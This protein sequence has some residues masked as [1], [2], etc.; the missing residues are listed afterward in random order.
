MERGVLKKYPQYT[1]CPYGHKKRFKGV[2]YEEDKSYCLR[3]GSGI[4]GSNPVYRMPGWFLVLRFRHKL[5]QQKQNHLL[6]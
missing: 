3:F 4:S 6:W 2:L 5:Q 1:L